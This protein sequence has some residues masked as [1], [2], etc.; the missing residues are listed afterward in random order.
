MATKDIKLDVNT[1][2]IVIGTETFDMSFVEGVEYIAQKLKVR[3]WFYL[4]EWFLNT[5][6]GTPLYGS[7]LVKNPDVGLISTLLKARILET[8]GVIEL[9]SFQFDYDNTL[10][11]ASVTFQCKTDAGELTISETIP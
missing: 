9:R 4:G 6:E 10:R 2:D 1:H 3:L 11:Q 5:D 7:I 8:P